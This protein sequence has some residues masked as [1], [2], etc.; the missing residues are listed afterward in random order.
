MLS[1]HL[2]NALKDLKDLILITKSDIEDIKK[3]QHDHSLKDC[4]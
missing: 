4:Q 3:A 1:H 2:Q